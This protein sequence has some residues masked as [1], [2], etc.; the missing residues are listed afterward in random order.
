L[1][2]QQKSLN[3]IFFLNIINTN[4]K[5]ASTPKNGSFGTTAEETFQFSGVHLQLRKESQW[6]AQQK[7]E[8]RTTD[9]EQKLD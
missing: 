8:E 3:I 2:L 1:V 4:K 5:T 6:L 9:T 7:Y